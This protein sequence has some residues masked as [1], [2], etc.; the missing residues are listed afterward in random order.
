VVAN[1]PLGIDF[2]SGFEGYDWVIGFASVGGL[3]GAFA[4]V[5]LSIRRH[6]W[7]FAHPLRQDPR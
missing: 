3:T 1:P 5:S 6:R 7:K 2:G 4:G